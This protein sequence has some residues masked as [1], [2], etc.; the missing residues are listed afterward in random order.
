[1]RVRVVGGSS[2]AWVEVA[3]DWGCAIEAVVVSSSRKISEVIPL[4]SKAIPTTVATALSLP[5]VSNWSG[6]L[7]STV[8]STADADL[9]FRMFENWLPWIAIIAFPPHFS[10]KQVVDLIPV[11][12]SKYTKKT[13]K[14]R[15]VQV[16]GVTVS[17][18]HILHWSRM[19]TQ[20]CRPSLMTMNV[21]PRTLQTALDDTKGG[22]L[23]KQIKSFETRADMGES[24]VGTLQEGG[25][26]E[27]VPVY[28][29]AKVGPDIS[30]MKMSNRFFWVEAAT[31][32]SKTPM[33]RQVTIEELHAIWDYEG[34]L[35]TSRWSKAQGSKVLYHRI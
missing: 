1:M 3:E 20:A 28:S 5:P 33:V 32:M 24:I 27:R 35:E 25:A 12:D 2:L 10:R 9:V 7:L 14:C 18:W 21:Y 17:A 8:C 19:T 31:V 29:A 22:R 13:Y 26:T 6:L 30:E 16:G 15:H 34:K 11:T 4:V 23:P